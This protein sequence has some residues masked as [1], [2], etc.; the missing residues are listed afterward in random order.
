MPTKLNKRPIQSIN[1][2][3]APGLLT[4]HSKESGEVRRGGGGAGKDPLER[5]A[6]AEGLLLG[7]YGAESDGGEGLSR[8]L[9]SILSACGTQTIAALREDVEEVV[10]QQPARLSKVD[11]GILQERLALDVDEERTCALA[12]LN[13]VV[14]SLGLR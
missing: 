6:S 7:G 1:K 9:G 5:G 4:P 13:R 3:H 2:G 14:S 11:V 10:R 12:H 8:A